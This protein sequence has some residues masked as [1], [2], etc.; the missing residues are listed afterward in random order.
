[1]INEAVNPPKLCSKASL[2]EMPLIVFTKVFHFKIS[3]NQL[4]T[5]KMIKKLIKG[6]LEKFGYR[7]SRIDSNVYPIDIPK[8]SIDDFKDV[9]QYTATSIERASAL[10]NSVE[11]IVNN[12]IIGDFVE[13]G[14]WKGGSCMLM[15]NKLNKLGD[16]DRE[17]WMYDTFDGMTEPTEDD[18]EVET[19]IKGK[20]LLTGIQ[21]NT[22]KYNMWAYA[23]IDEVKKN[24]AS[25]GYPIDKVKFIIGKVE[26][27]LLE[28]KPQRI[29]LLR[30]DTDWYESTKIEL[31][32]LYPLISQGGVLIIDD[33]GHFEGARK[34]V[35][36]YFKKTKQAPLL[37][38][39]DYTG[40]LIIKK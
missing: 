40:R 39:I 34:A 20:D 33:Y 17:I 28:Y 11:Y 6:I 8:E 30:L 22:D 24:I 7:I 38:R 2:K 10:L 5:L 3:K 35:N 18:V 21:K 14:V 23:P 16:V 25:T 9:E 19:G 15:A 26:E 4:K 13:C 29:A 36:D 1:V 27:T 37:N 32:M 31:D 12:E